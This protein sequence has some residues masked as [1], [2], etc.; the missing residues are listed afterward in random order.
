VLKQDRPYVI[1]LISA[2]IDGRIAFGPDLTMFDRHPAEVLVT[3][4]GPI[5]GRVID[6]IEAE[7]HPQ[8]SM[9]GSG[10]F[11]RENA[12]LRELPAFAG[13][14]EAL[15]VDFLP[16]EVVA[17]TRKWDILVDGRARCRGGYK[18]TGKPGYHILH[19]VSRSAPV[20]YL[21]FLRQERIPY[22]IS[23]QEHADLAEALSKLYAILGIRAIC[24]WGGGTLNGAMLRAGL[25]DE[26]HLIVWPLLIG[27]R[28]TPTLADCDDLPSDGL[29]AV[30][31]LVSAQIQDGGYLWLHYKATKDLGS[32][33]RHPDGDASQ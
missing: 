5:G 6:A 9:W 20:E 31:E 26:I 1:M 29:P 8:G 23:G 11:E 4:S 33:A 7:W 28:R 17:A 12:P 22:L 14:A 19:L 32:T 10:T 21:A 2:S 24:L 13:D 3:D 18:S 25:I 30:F 16:E 15:Y 27:G